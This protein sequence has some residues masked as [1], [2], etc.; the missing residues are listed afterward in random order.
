MNRPLVFASLATASV[1]L[2]AACTGGN[3]GTDG[4]G[5]AAQA[6]AG[7]S[8]N[9]T[10]NTGGHVFFDGGVGGEAG[11]SAPSV[12][13]AHTNTTLYSGDPTV[14]PLTLD[15]LG[16]FDCIGGAGQATSMT[17][18]A[19]DRAGNVWAVSSNAIYRIE[20]QGA[21]VHCAQT[22]S[23]NNP[24]GIRFYGLT[25]APKGVLDPQKEV[26]VAGNNAGELWSIDDNGNL[27]QH[28]TFGIV[29]ANDGHGHTYANAGKDWELSGDIAFFSN[30]GNPVGFA[31][32]RDCP[33]PPDT[34]GC[35]P[36][37]TL[38]ELDVNAI[39]GATSQ[40]VTQSVRGQIVKAA[41]C[42]DAA[43]G[44]GSVY[45][46]AAWGGVVHGFSRSSGDGYAIAIDNTDGSA[47]LLDF[48]AGLS[49]AGAGVT[50]A[51]PIV[52]PPN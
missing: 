9:T 24:G 17:D 21:V 50:T 7:G 51:A 27:A 10:T 16:D 11:G 18:V 44:Y 3:A 1:A 6:G 32:V 34:T 4:S 30:A 23:L 49:W 15:L 8:T 2:F 36:I 12:L 31:T 26:L 52:A 48:F 40:S 5:A 37:D 22:I 38:V 46:I 33:N 20:I 19:V 25:F 14:S 29:P 42:S 39:G 47:C 13:Y 43:A 28:G 45:G 35:N 41:G